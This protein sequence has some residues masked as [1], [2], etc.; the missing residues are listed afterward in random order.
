M[1]F[2]RIIFVSIIIKIVL[3][4]KLQTKLVLR[5]FQR[6]FYPFN[7]IQNCTNA[8]DETFW[9]QVPF[10]SFLPSYCIYLSQMSII[11]TLKTLRKENFMALKGSFGIITDKITY[12]LKYIVKCTNVV[13]YKIIQTILLGVV[14]YHWND[15]EYDKKIRITL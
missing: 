11:Q 1:I 12:I 7:I 9:L 3:Y 10:Y 5:I 6:I 15:Y 14:E 13:I 2:L 8:S 4:G